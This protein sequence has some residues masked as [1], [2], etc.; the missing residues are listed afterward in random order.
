MMKAAMLV[1]VLVGI[2]ADRSE[3]WWTDWIISRK[4]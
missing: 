3:V 1:D 4:V 2:L